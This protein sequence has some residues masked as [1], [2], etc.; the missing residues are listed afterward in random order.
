V[1]VVNGFFLQS[2]NNRFL[3]SKK[4]FPPVYY[5]KR[6]ALHYIEKRLPTLFALKCPNPFNAKEYGGLLS[7]DT[8]NKS[9]FK[10]RELI[11]A[12]RRDV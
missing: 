8:L 2:G 6:A 4:N 10:N 1:N 9:G 12:G 5:K 11:N 7:A 3:R